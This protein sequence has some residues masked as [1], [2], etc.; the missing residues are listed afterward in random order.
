MK[1]R[2]RDYSSGMQIQ[3]FYDSE[4]E[5]RFLTAAACLADSAACFAASQAAREYD[6][7]AL[8]LH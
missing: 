2:D 4:L 7:C 1:I 3:R 8:S 6:K 5:V